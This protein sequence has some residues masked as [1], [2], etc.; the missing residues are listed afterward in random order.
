MTSLLFGIIISA[1]L[2]TTSL[3]AILFRVSPLTSPNQ[4]IPAFFASVLLSVSS[5]GILLF[6][7]LWKVLPVHAWDAGKMLSVSVRQGILL[8]I[9]TTV[10]ILFHLL[11]LLNWAVGILIYGVFI[12]VEIAMNV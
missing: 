2:S 6:Y 3:I 8:G 7:L 1:L 12:L 4:A 11:G 9:A 10:M 5:V